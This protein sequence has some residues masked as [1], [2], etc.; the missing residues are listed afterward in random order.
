MEILPILSTIILVGTI[1]TFVLAI[2]AYWLYKS[3]EKSS[4]SAGSAREMA[5]EPHMLEAPAYAPRAMYAQ[6]QQALRGRGGMMMVPPSTAVE[7]EMGASRW[8][9]EPSRAGVRSA[10]VDAVPAQD[11]V[12]VLAVGVNEPLGVSTQFVVAEGVAAHAV[13]L[14]EHHDRRQAQRA[15]VDPPAAAEVG[16]QGLA[17]QL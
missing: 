15:P 7:R 13:G 2:C 11:V 8:T 16:N 9:S 6:Q 5:Y 17:D 12:Q 14:V 3:R 1:A 4:A 10:D